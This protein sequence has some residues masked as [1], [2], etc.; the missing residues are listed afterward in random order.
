LKGTSTTFS[1]ENC[2]KKEDPKLSFPK[3]SGGGKKSYR[4]N[5]SAEST[6]GKVQTKHS[7]EGKSQGI[8][9]KNG[10]TTKTF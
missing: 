2:E 3:D 1:W 8:S 10:T 5:K 4:K 6:I 9:T 7:G